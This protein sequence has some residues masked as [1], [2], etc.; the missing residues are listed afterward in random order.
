MQRAWAGYIDFNHFDSNAIIGPHPEVE[1]L[2]FATGFHGHG[3][4]HSPAAGRAMMELIALG[5][6]RTLDLRR[7]GYARVLA[8]EPLVE[9]YV[10]G[11]TEAKGT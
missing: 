11:E 2:L 5:G 7:F 1:G 6:Y 4:M 8:R 9:S 10:F 3:V